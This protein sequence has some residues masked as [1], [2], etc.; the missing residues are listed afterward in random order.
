MPGCAAA[1]SEHS[2]A[3]GN[4]SGGTA[5]DSSGVMTLRNAEAIRNRDVL[6]ID[7]IYTTGAT[8]DGAAEVLLA[9]GARQVYVLTFAAGADVV[10]SE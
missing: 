1:Q 7:D 3:S 10:K 4:D 5:A 9:G 2:A 8:V 6:L